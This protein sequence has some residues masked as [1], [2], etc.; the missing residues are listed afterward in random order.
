MRPHG[1]QQQLELR[2]FE[3]ITLLKDG[4][5]PGEISG[6]LGVDRRSVRRWKA[7]FRKKGEPAIKALQVPGRPSKLTRNKKKQLERNLL[8]G[9][10]YAGYPTDLWSGRRVAKLIQ[11]I[12]HIT[13]HPAHVCR[14]LHS[15]G[16]TP[17]KPERRAKERN[18]RAI[19]N[20]IKTDWELIKKKRV[21]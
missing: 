1:T 12:F 17:Q 6:R 18:E 5:L 10:Q 11:K 2:R 7:S 15:M 8:K 13:Y 20:W 4:L 19:A 21:H 3:A 16:W 14:L 9:A